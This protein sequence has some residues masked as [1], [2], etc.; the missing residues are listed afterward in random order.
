MKTS[1]AN[2]REENTVK[3]VNHAEA[4]KIVV[5]LPVCLSFFILS[6][7]SLLDIQLRRAV[8][9]PKRLFICVR[10]SVRI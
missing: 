1:L 8:G 2:Q 7:Y 9:F 3:F 4:E 6:V 10:R 5:P